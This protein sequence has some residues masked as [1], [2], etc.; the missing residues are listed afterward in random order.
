MEVVF[1]NVT[2]YRNYKSLIQKKLLSN[3]DMVIPKNKITAIYGDY[4]KNIIGP[5]ICALETPSVGSII[6]GKHVI[7]R[8]KYIN[9]IND[10][11]FE[12]GYAP[13]DPRKYLFKKTVKA[14]V[15][16]GMKHYKY[17]LNR[18]QERPLDALKLVGLDS[19]YEKR[20][21]QNLSLSEQK[22]VMIASI[23]AYNPKIIIFDEIE[24]G[25]NNIDRN[26]IIRLI[27]TL[28]DKYQRTIIL[29]SNDIEFI[30]KCFDH[31]YVIKESKL[32]F[33]CEISDLYNQNI[34]RHIQ[35]P[36]IV[37]FVKKARNK[38]AK[39]EDFYEF[40]ELIKGVY[41]DVK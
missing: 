14:E 18:I 28:K 3:I 15:E 13:S 7:K 26:N 29:I 27:K 31:I 22:K 35:L 33:T 10:L 30:F 39:I 19:S 5:L 20:N 9:N 38:G 21:P 2:V 24:K 25:L 16:Y 8:N 32:V 12:V 11:R 40:N 41:R 34:D 1:K 36:Q 23:I 17:R 6:V 37:D 4:N